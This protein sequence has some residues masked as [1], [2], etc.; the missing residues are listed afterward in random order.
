M[1]TILLVI[2]T[3]IVLFLI[4]IILIQKPDGDGLSGLGGGSG[5][6]IMSGRAA[7][8]AITRTTAILATIFIISSLGLAVMSGGQHK[9]SIVDKI[10]EQ[11]ADETAPTPKPDSVPKPE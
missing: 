9:T 3:I 7:G 8:N 2:H 4:G 10:V 1:F 5:G 6:N 11:P